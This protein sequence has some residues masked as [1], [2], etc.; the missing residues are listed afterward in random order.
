MFMALVFRRP[1]HPSILGWTK[2]ASQI[3]YESSDPATRMAIA[4]LLAVS[5]IWMGNY[6]KALAT[7]RAMQELAASTQLSPLERAHLKI[8]ESMYYLL[9][10]DRQT[11]LDAVEEGLLVTEEHG[12]QRWGKQ[13]Q[14]TRLGALLGDGDLDGARTR[15][16]EME[17]Y[18]S[19]MRRL[20]G[21]LY[22]YFRAW[23]YM[24][25]GDALNAF[26]DQKKAVNV[27]EELG[28]PFFEVLCRLALSHLLYECGDERKGQVELK[29]VHRLARDIDN[30]L[31]EYMTLLTYAHI[32]ITN[33]KYR[34]GLNS[35]RYAMSVGR[36]H[37]YT[38]SL[39]WNPKMMSE[40]CAV[41]LDENIE[42]E[43]VRSLIRTRTLRPPA[44]AWR[45]QSWPWR[46]KIYTLGT[47]QL[48]VDD[49]LRTFAGKS[50]TRS[51]EL[52]KVLIALGGKD[53]RAEQVAEAV[54]S[55]VDGDYAYRS[56]T[57]T[58]HRLRKLLGSDESVL[59]EDGKLRLN[60]DLVWTDVWEMEQV[61]V[62]AD[63]FIRSSAPQTEQIQSAAESLLEVY[64][65][66]FLDDETEQGCYIALH[67]HLRHRFTRQ[68]RRLV[69]YWEQRSEWEVALEY[70]E[71]GLEVDSCSEV[72]YREVMLCN[73]ALGRVSEAIDAYQRCHA[74]LTSAL[75]MSP[76]SETT[77]IFE[78]LCQPP[79]AGVSR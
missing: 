17:S 15:L 20:D 74:K 7:I 38:H 72:F 25:C 42:R 77:R 63:T 46:F 2:T 37:N 4:P 64:R 58:L 71:R 54:W 70:Y 31:L 79:A 65:G 19:G 14:L 52:L 51:L 35:L 12:I 16:N 57:T 11:C 29:K 69:H 27:A 45:Q 23:H 3:A 40:L 18:R 67:E 47:F 30:H 66:A 78:R 34:S 48:V 61:V 26:Q 50:P 36:N 41:A 1:D 49:K 10:G 22:F 24:L 68:L 21:C 60:Q 75:R 76:G 13:L 59:L 44:T 32:A 53:V 33:G 6:S 8:A 62:N 9:T 73:E 56:F 28:L 55:H 5:A 39:W 43:Y